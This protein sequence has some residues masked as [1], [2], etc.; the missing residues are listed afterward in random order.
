MGCTIDQPSGTRDFVSESRQKWSRNWATHLL[1][2]VVVS[3]LLHDGTI[4]SGL[5]GDAAIPGSSGFCTARKRSKATHHLKRAVDL[6][7]VI[8][9][10]VP[11]ALW[12]MSWSIDKQSKERPRTMSEAG[13]L[14]STREFLRANVGFDFLHNLLIAPRRCEP[15][16]RISSLTASFHASHCSER[17]APPVAWTSRS[18]LS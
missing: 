1:D 10:P 12:L 3:N 16:R 4:S 13:A 17:T 6:K 14:R 18:S 9:T 15:F 8:Q 2:R 11:S 7:Q 5:L